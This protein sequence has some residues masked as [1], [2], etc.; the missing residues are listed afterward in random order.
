VPRHKETGGEQ[1]R[2]NGGETLEQLL[3]ARMPQAAKRTLKQ[4]VEHGRVIVAGS[5]ARRLDSVV[6]AGASVRITPRGSGQTE[7]PPLPPG[8]NLVHLDEDIAV[9]EKPPGL[10]TIATEREKRRTAYAYLREHL[11]A[12]DPASKVFIVHRLDRYTSGLLVFARTPQAKER[13]QADFAAHRVDRVYVAAVH[14]RLERDEGTL[15][16]YLLESDALKVHVTNDRSRGVE[17]V[18][19][20]RVLKRG[21]KITLVEVSLVT[22]R[23]AQIRVQFAA[24]GHPV[25][26]DRV[27]GERDD[28]IGRLALHASRL[29]FAHPRLMRRV[30]FQSRVPREITGLAEED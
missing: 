20:F 24:E 10:L 8:L 19:R 2:A 15:T 1:F 22:G 30:Q 25:A 26:G 4:L 3:A 5:V 23:K 21:R 14:G 11:K 7:P 27:Y 17:A 16:S 13:L 9:V 12:T 6:P 29:A 18:T 28:M